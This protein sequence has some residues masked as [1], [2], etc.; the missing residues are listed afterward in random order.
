MPKR[1][2]KHDVMPQVTL[3]AVS[4]SLCL[5]FHRAQAMS[6]STPTFPTLPQTT[7]RGGEDVGRKDSEH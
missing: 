7:G 1:T 3:E 5:R 4:F 2:E 6:T